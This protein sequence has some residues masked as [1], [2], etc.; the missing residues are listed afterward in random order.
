MIWTIRPPQKHI[1]TTLKAFL[2]VFVL[3]THFSV[4]CLNKSNEMQKFVG[5]VERAASD[6]YTLFMLV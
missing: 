3:R 2:S 5:S 4:V 6:F 1:P